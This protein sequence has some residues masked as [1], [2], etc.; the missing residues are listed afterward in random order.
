M[1]L[2]HD[3]NGF[4]VVVHELMHALGFFHEHNRPDRDEHVYVN[5]T[6]IMPGT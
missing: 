1:N 2:A 4:D 6:N 3:C 5:Y